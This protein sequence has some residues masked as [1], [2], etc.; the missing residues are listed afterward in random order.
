MEHLTAPEIKATQSTTFLD[1]FR[2]LSALYIVIHHARYLLHEGYSEGYQLH[3][4]LYNALQKAGMYGLALFGYGHQ[5]V[6]FFFVL[7]GFVIHLRYAKQLKAQSLSA[8]FDVGHYFWRRA[9]R[10]YPPLLFALALTFALDQWGMHLG[11]AVYGG[12]TPSVLIN[13]TIHPDHRIGTF[14]GNLMFLMDRHIAGQAQNYVP[15][16]GTD[17]PLWSLRYEA[18]FY[19]LY[20][21]FWW[22][23]RR[24]TVISTTS[25]LVLFGLSFVPGIWPVMLLRDIFEMMLVWWLGALLAEIYAGRLSIRWKWLVPLMLSPVAMALHPGA[26]IESVLWGLGFCGLISAGFA[27]QEAGWT[28]RPI[29]RLQ[30]LGD[31]SYSLYVMHMPILVFVSGWLMTRTPDGTLPHH[32]GPMML[33]CAGVLVF[34]YAVHWIVEQPFIRSSGKKRVSPQLEVLVS[35]AR[36]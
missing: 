36:A 14:L 33:I 4:Q 18:W 20:P 35:A 9:R 21:I 34:A 2:G 25:M 24:S 27:L 6:L 12:H 29:N 16:F 11:F 22:M 1:G 31:M 3:P 10:L 15:V 28:L 26:A 23:T 30:F 17:D 7:S 19:S 8:R 5:M 32:F 13:S